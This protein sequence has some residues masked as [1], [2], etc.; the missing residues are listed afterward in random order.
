MVTDRLLAAVLDANSRLPDVTFLA[1]LGRPASAITI[2]MCAD[3]LIPL[4]LYQGSDLEE[5]LTA[6]AS[7][8]GSLE[9]SQ[10]VL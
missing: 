3:Y 5:A 8:V 1:L 9:R 2:C 4:T 6:L 7:A 10:K